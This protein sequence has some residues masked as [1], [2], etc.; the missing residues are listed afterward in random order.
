MANILEEA[1]EA[2][3]G[4]RRSD[5]GSPRD[6]HGCTAEF[7]TSWLKRRGKLREGVQLDAYD[8]CYMNML[9]KESR[10][11]HSPK[12][13]NEVDIAGYARNVELL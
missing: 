7:W 11:A 10:A 8:V 4:A 3:E 13:D 6:N 5:Y 2:V 1:N 12:R 9:Q